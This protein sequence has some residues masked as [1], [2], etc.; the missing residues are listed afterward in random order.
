M[1]TH[2]HPLDVL[3]AALSTNNWDWAVRYT[4]DPNGTKCVRRRAWPEGSHIRRGGFPLFRHDENG[5]VT[6]TIYP[7]HCRVNATNTMRNLSWSPT[8][9]DKAATDWEVYDPA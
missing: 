5:R 2:E 9:E 3:Q 8:A 1:P 4:D 6:E 7:G